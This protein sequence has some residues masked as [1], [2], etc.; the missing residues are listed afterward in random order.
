MSDRSQDSQK[1]IA[2][3]AEDLTVVTNVAVA[4][5]RSF[6]ELTST[7]DSRKPAYILAKPKGAPNKTPDLNPVL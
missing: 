5:G 1:M 7:T 6:T 4:G 3:V 2:S